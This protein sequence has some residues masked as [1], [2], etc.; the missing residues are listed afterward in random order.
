MSKSPREDLA[1]VPVEEL[2]D[3]T[4]TTE[5]RRLAREIAHHD[6]LY[7]QK[8]APEIS[9]ADYDTLVKRNRAIE[10]R[11]PELIRKDSPS[12][13]VG[14]AP[15]DAARHAAARGEY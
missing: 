1:K 3:K 6:E 10:A 5:L 4:A 14:A 11:F 7:H 15:A 9:D 2:T 12:R 13:K 8:D